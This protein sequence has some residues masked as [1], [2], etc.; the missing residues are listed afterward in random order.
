MDLASVAHS[1]WCPIHPNA[2]LVTSFNF[3]LVRTPFSFVLAQSHLVPNLDRP[4]NAHSKAHWLFVSKQCESTHISVCLPGRLI[5]SF[6]PRNHEHCIH[7]SSFS[8]LNF[9]SLAESHYSLWNRGG[10]EKKSRSIRSGAASTDSIGALIVFF[11]YDGNWH[12]WPNQRTS[13]S[14]S[15]RKR[16]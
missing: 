7:C 10:W 16:Q 4:S 12:L 3:S 8:I 9:V 5:D 14:I 6:I 11:K 15:I 13:T 1:P 2:K